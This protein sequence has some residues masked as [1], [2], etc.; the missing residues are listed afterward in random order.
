MRK[1]YKKILIAIIMI[2]FVFTLVSQ[3]K[4]LNTYKA[5]EKDYSK[6]IDQAQETNKTLVATK[7]NVTSI[8][9]IEKAAREKLDMYLP[10]ERVYI[11]IEK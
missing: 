1:I 2:Y 11:D 7:Q 6:K 9:Y 3:Q 10:N 5:A 4:T 8:D